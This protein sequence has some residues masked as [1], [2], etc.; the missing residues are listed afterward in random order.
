MRICKNKEVSSPFKAADQQQSVHFQPL[1]MHQFVESVPRQVT[2]A[3][4]ATT[5]GKKTH[6]SR[7][8]LHPYFL[9]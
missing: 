5:G 1:N 3:V 4:E 9:T 8:G 2:L 6:L 7:W